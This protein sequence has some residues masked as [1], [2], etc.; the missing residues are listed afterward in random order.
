MDREQIS[1]D[2]KPLV[3][4]KGER[5]T[6]T[7]GPLYLLVAVVTYVGKT[8][9]Q[10]DSIFDFVIGVYRRSR[11]VRETAVQVTAL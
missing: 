10:A 7:K 11:L 9:P 4:L 5:P 8:M 2:L 6:H 3:D 1:S